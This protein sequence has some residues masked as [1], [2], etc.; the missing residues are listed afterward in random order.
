MSARV[1]YLIL[2]KNAVVGP[3]NVYRK[4]FDMCERMLLSIF[5]R[6]VQY[7]HIFTA[8]YFFVE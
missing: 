8:T 5:I 1:W 4:C 7:L 2:Y 6:M 3:C